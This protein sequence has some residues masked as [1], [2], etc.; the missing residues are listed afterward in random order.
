MHFNHYQYAAQR[1]A[2]DVAAAHTRRHHRNLLHNPN[3]TRFY[4]QWLAQ[5]GTQLVNMGTRLQARYD[6]AVTTAP[7]VSLAG[8]DVDTAPCN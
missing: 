1:R 2:D 7:V 3:A 8:S 4:Q 6:E 5:L